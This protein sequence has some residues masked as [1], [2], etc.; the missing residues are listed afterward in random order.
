[1]VVDD[2]A[3]AVP[4]DVA[5]LGDIDGGRRVG[6]RSDRPERD[7]ANDAGRE[8]TPAS[9]GVGGRADYGAAEGGGS[10]NGT[11]GLLQDR[12]DGSPYLKRGPVVRADGRPYALAA[13]SRLCGEAREP[14]QPA[15]NE[16]AVGGCSQSW[17][18]CPVAWIKPRHST[19]ERR[20]T[21]RYLVNSIRHSALP[22]ER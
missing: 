1:M 6:L 3:A 9:L 5:A 11:D 20:T 16:Q 10:E 22:G 15:R 13:V 2:A 21:R 19:F 12:H 14:F 17:A 7:A 4:P 8:S 18:A